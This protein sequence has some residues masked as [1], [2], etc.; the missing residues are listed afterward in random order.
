MTL[1]T[2]SYGGGVQS[3]AMVVL[4][5]TRDPAFEKAMGGPVDAALFSNVG[6]DSEHPATVAY[7][8]D[9]VQPWAADRGLPVHELHRQLRDGTTETLWGRIMREGAR[10]M[11]IPVRF[12]NGAPGTRACTADFKIRVVAKWLK[13]AG[14]CKDTPAT[15]AIGI[16]TDEIERINNRRDADH[17]QAAYPLIELRMDRQDCA[18][19]I[20]R[21]GLPV[22]PKSACFFCPFHRPQMWAEMRRD[23]PELFW[24]SVELERVMNERRDMLEKD[25]VYLTRFGKP[26]DEA[27]PE[28]QDQLPGFES[29]GETGC[30][31][32]Y[33]FT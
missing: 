20:V 26:L 30:D 3:T 14:A 8:R 16:S 6:D 21:A 23:E 13:A 18:N 15:V 22:P 32:G 31:S 9:V 4:A 17:E 11:P 29:I 24:R 10:S 2:I 27:I 7:V 5:A 19:T 1:R 28:A 33:C 12:S 25:H